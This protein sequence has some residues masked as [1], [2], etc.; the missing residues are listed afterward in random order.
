MTTRRCHCEPT[1]RDGTS[2]F[3]LT[4]GRTDGDLSYIEFALSE[5]QCTDIDGR[6]GVLTK[7]L[8]FGC[9]ES[10]CK[11]RSEDCPRQAPA[12]FKIVLEAGDRAVTKATGLP[13]L[14]SLK[15]TVGGHVHSTEETKAF[16]TSLIANQELA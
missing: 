5:L 4:Y 16:Q 8:F 6:T 14:K 2:K 11:V 12:K 10:C 15:A 3:I 1:G 7:E 9:T 13:R